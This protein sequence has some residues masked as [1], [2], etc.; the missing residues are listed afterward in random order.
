ML[1]LSN[2]PPYYI[3]FTLLFIDYY[4]HFNVALLEFAL[5]TNILTW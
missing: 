2:L 4:Y 5:L 1:V 3:G